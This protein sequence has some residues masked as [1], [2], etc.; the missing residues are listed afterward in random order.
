MQDFIYPLSKTRWHEACQG[1][2]R[3]QL[4]QLIR[5][6]FAEEHGATINSFLPRLFGLWQGKRP[7]AALG[8]RVGH[9]GPLFQEHY[10]N[11]SVESFLG[12]RSGKA[13]ARQE[14]AEI[15]N[16]VTLRPGLQRYMFLQLVE[17]MTY[18][19]VA[20]LIFT[21][22]PEVAN[23]IHRLGLTLE[24]VMPADPV[25]LGPEKTDH[26]GNYYDRHP[27]VMVGDLKRAYRELSARG[28]LPIKSINIGGT[29]GAQH[30]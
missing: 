15:G 11:E 5:R 10:L 19:G 12:S 24:R 2:E 4:E 30:V 25:R 22:T 3:D 27:W 21:A 20:W 29:H 8:I 26:W 6:R 1:E 16:L 18:E 13:P 23:G 28:L 7:F 14:I 17:Q 9:T